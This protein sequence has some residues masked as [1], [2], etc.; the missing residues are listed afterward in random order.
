MTKND[1]P[2]LRK[3]SKEGKSNLDWG[4][5]MNQTIIKLKTN[6]DL[7]LGK[8]ELTKNRVENQGRIKDWTGIIGQE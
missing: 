4:L 1:K 3:E 8:E 6:L 5:E 7:G 2:G